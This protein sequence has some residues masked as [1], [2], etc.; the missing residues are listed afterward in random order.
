MGLV[1][2]LARVVSQAV[3]LFRA[4]RRL[5]AGGEEGKMPRTLMLKSAPV[6][7]LAEMLPDTHFPSCMFTTQTKNTTFVAT[8]TFSMQLSNA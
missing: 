2:F 4:G 6:S 8:T 3:G 7:V 1:V 5:H